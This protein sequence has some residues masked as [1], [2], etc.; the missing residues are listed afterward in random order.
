MTSRA[1]P[2]VKP[3]S[4]QGTN[5]V[6]LGGLGFIGRALVSRL[7]L[8]GGP[9]LIR[10]LDS[11]TSGTAIKQTKN[12]ELHRVDVRNRIEVERALRDCSIVF[13]LVGQGGHLESMRDP[14]SDL[15]SNIRAQL[16]ILEACQTVAPGAHVIFA[17]TRQVYGV[18][19]QLPVPEHHPA[20][21]IDING[22]HKLTAERYHLLYTQMQAVQ[23][24]VLRL[25]NTYG[26]GMRTSG[27]NSTFLGSWIHN[28]IEGTPIPVYGNGLGVRDLTHIDDVVEA[29][30]QAATHPIETV[31]EIFNIGSG[32]PVTLLEIAQ[33]LASMSHGRSK[34]EFHPFPE[35]LKRIDIGDYVSDSTKFTARTGWR[36]R[37]PLIDG[38]RATLESFGLYWN[39]TP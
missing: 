32:N 30:L 34:I 19:Q 22:I 6:V 14:D 25:T 3:L 33:N 20:N 17:S 27:A 23:S 31:G 5:V 10:V 8:E 11:A 36:A 16:N 37:T 13:N 28:L 15:E 9:E 7:S 12:I 24:T 38:L 35:V 39:L 1:L 29:F 4:L 21:P 18:P 26:S 2:H